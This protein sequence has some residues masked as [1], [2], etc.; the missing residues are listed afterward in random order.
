MRAL[1][2]NIF[3]IICLSSIVGCTSEIIKTQHKAELAVLMPLSGP[4]GKQG[5]K[6]AELV[7]WGIEDK[8]KTHI[9]VKI[10]DVSTM[11]DVE[12]AAAKMVENKTQ[13]ILGPIYSP[14]VK[15][16]E[17][18]VAERNIVMLTLSNNPVS[19]VEDKIFI[20]GHNYLKQSNQILDYLTKVGHKDFVI[21]MPKSKSSKNLNKVYEEMIKAKSAE[22]VL[23]AEYDNNNESKID[24]V[25]TI[26]ELVDDLIENVDNERKPVILIS[27]DKQETI[28]EIY[29]LL[30]KQHLDSKAVIAGD[31]RLDTDFDEN[32]NYIFTGSNMIP[33]ANLKEKASEQLKIQH[34]N[35]LESLSYDLGSF[36]ADSIGESYLRKDFIEKIKRPEGYNGLSGHI[37]FQDTIANRK[38]SIIKRTGKSYKVIDGPKSN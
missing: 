3:I 28:K 10:Y 16:L 20:F 26:A 9:S 19:A 4:M 6:L 33:K 27:E 8:L 7:K 17:R 14:S 30:K 21:L 22:I 13:I 12:N 31:S 2:K 18:F 15:A 25:N 23:E 32:I 36:I 24:A 5:E 1:I 11:E 35:Y 34:F 29:S 38:Y 37:I